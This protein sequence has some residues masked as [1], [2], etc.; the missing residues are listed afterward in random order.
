MLFYRW[1]FC[2]Q[3]KPRFA[4]A[5]IVC[6]SPNGG[7]HITAAS[8]PEPTLD[9]DVAKVRFE[10]LVETCFQC[11]ARRCHQLNQLF[12]HLA[13]TGTDFGYGYRLGSASQ[14][15]A[16]YFGD[17]KQGETTMKF[18]RQLFCSAAMAL[19]LLAFPMTASAIAGAHM[20]ATDDI[21][22]VLTLDLA[23]GSGCS[24]RSSD[25]GN[26]RCNQG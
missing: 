8:G 1:Q 22:W 20:D 15:S 10:T 4:D 17:V 14:E 9:Q 7:I 25:G 21:S 11:F 13:D 19:G 24:F 16:F 18:F 5:T 12:H 3:S 26:G 6:S 23:E 2:L